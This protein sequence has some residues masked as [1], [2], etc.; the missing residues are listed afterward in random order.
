MIKISSR[1]VQCFTLTMSLIIFLQSIFSTGFCL[2]I[3]QVFPLFFIYLQAVFLRTS[4]P[5][6]TFLE[7]RHHGRCVAVNVSNNKKLCF[8]RF[9]SF[10][11][12]P[13][14]I[15]DIP[16]KK[17]KNAITTLSAILFFPPRQRE[18]S[19]APQLSFV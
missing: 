19:H 11:R 16:I 15:P 18:E 17:T 5:L 8:S 10:D 9:I 3:F 13:A 2:F 14:S 6:F 4:P 1:F 7:L 12:R